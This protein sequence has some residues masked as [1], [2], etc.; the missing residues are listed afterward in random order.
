MQTMKRRRP[1][2]F[3]PYPKHLQIAD[4]L[5]NRLLT[6]MQPGERIEPEVVLSEQ[7]GVSR[8]TIRQ[9]LAPLERDGLITRFRGRGSFVAKQLPYRAPKKKLTGLAEDFVQGLNYELVRKDLVQGDDEAAAFLKAE[10]TSILVRIDRTSSHEGKVLAYHEAFLPTSVGLRVMQE[11]LEH[12]SVAALLTGPC[13]Y[14]LEEDQQ[15]IEADVCD[16]RLSGF[17]GVPIGF[18]VL[19][20]RRIYISEGE[21]PIAYFKSYYRA[22]RYMYTVA[23]R[24]H[25]DHHRLVQPQREPA[26]NPMHSSA[27]KARKRRAHTRAEAEPPARRAG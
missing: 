2:F 22:D 13:G 3:H 7:F 1:R 19:V 25:D 20:M 21:Q 17:L 5:R 27:V 4:I 18:P 8:E 10:R 15:I 14:K 16:V 11:D 23:L 26:S 9:A 24:Q 12:S 6:Q